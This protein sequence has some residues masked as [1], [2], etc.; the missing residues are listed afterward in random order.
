MQIHKY[1][2]KDAMLCVNAL[3]SRT[4]LGP[5]AAPGG[6]VF[7]LLVLIVLALIGEYDDDGD[8][9]DDDDHNDDDDDLHEDNGDENDDDDDV[10]NLSTSPSSSITILSG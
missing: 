1:K 5:I 2:Y 3:T 9:D 4:M 10:I 8:D 7:A 6:S